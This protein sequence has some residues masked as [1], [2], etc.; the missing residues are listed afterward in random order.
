MCQRK[1]KDQLVICHISKLINYNKS[2]SK[3]EESRRKK[4]TNIRIEING[5]GK[6]SNYR[7]AQE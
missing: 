5:M 7:K 6:R 4:V 2:N 1:I 3:I